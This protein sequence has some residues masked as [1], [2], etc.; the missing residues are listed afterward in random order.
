MKRIF[1][2][3]TFSILLY[4][5]CTFEKSEAISSDC[6][7]PVSYSADVDTI[8]SL[9]CGGCHGV[10]SLDGNLTDYA[11]LKTKVESGIFKSKVFITK[12]MPQGGP[13]LPENELGKLKCWMEQG[14]LNN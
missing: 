11:V 7:S 10:G 3:A 1:L 14:A 5:S 12:E 8:I 4:S 13:A 2:I 9:R 6:L